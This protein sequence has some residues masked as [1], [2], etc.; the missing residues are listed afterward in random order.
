V[1]AG[2]RREPATFG[3]SITW[4]VAMSKPKEPV[5]ERNRRIGRRESS[6]KDGARA[7][8]AASLSVAEGHHGAAAAGEKRPRPR[9]ET[10]QALGR[11]TRATRAGKHSEE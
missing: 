8:D 5:A 6:I 4:T 10:E 11:A 1:I 2:T 9:S 7:G 3:P